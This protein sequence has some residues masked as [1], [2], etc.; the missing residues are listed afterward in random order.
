MLECEEEQACIY[1]SKAVYDQCLLLADRSEYS[2]ETVKRAVF[3]NE[4]CTHSNQIEY[5]FDH[6]PEPLNILAPYLGRVKVDVEIPM[7]LRFMCGVLHMLSMAIDFELFAKSPAA[8]RNGLYF[9]KS[10]VVK[11]EDSWNDIEIKLKMSE[12]DMD[13]ISIEAVAAV[14]Q[15]FLPVFTMVQPMAYVPQTMLN[16]NNMQAQQTEMQDTDEEEDDEAI[17]AAMNADLSSLFA[18]EDDKTVESKK[19][20]EIKEVEELEKTEQIMDE[21]QKQ[22]SEIDRIIAGISGGVL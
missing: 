11:F 13:K 5:F 4:T 10:S 18:D 3:G 8:V 2:L 14:L 21:A 19:I 12:I 6:A 20:V 7:D 1:L 15:K 16:M 22:I 9:K 17:F